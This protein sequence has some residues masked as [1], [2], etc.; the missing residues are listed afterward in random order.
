M[1]SS[2]DKIFYFA[3]LN[4]NV[5]EHLLFAFYLILFAWLVTKVK[6]FTSSG[7]TSS[8]LVIL[9]LFKVMAGIFYG[10][11]GIYYGEMA[12]MIDTW[13]YHFESLQEYA[14]LKKDPLIFFTNLFQSNYEGGYGNFLSTENS[15]W[16]DVKAN[17][18]IK[19][20]AIFNL[21]SF[22]QYYTNIIFYSFFTMFGPMAIYRVMKD[23]YSMGNLAVLLACFFIPSFLYWT[24][25]LHKEGLIFFGLAMVIYHF[26]FGFKEDRF[27]LT[28]IL[29]IIACLFLILILRNFLII[30][31]LPPLLGWMLS[32][33][34]KKPVL[35]FITIAA[36]SVILFFTSKYID[37]QLDLPQATL[38]KQKEFFNLSGGSTVPVKEL[39]PDFIGFV[40]NAPQA[41]SLSIIRPY[42]SDVS[43]L[44]SLAA[45]IEINILL[46]LFII[47]LIWKKKG[48]KI[49]ALLLFLLFF[50]FAELMMVG[51][52]VN[53]LG[54]IVRYRSIVLPLLLIPVVANINWKRINELVFK[55]DIK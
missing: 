40:K 50:S 35:V 22:G 45:A 47:F 42:P 19:I 20:M 15:W 26:Y 53:N 9:F 3:R 25:G 10:W 7:L 13:G 5:L 4:Q 46:F 18:L 1:I 39:E 33:K 11:I 52:T 29:A 54:A 24:S 28:R 27:R 51:Y 30:I 32:E 43:H 6:F 23:H 31:L 17:M 44:L 21:F 14:L 41:L 48:N 34:F 12:K 8:Q 55:N 37:P 16:N 38:T 2:V 49:S 36:V